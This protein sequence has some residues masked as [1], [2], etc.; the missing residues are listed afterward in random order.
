MNTTAIGQAAEVLAAEWLTARGLRLIEKNA[1]T[2]FF[3]LDIVMEQGEQVVFV[4]VKYRINEHFGGGAAAISADK[5]RRLLAGAQAWLIER[6]WYDRPIRF[7]VVAVTGREGNRKL[8]HF[9]DCL[10]LDG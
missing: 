3:E 8:Q 4:E 5:Q 1:R 9:A 2:R 6:G 7:D 10:V